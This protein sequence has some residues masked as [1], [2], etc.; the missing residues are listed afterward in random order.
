MNIYFPVALVYIALA[1]AIIAVLWLIVGLF[2]WVWS[3]ATDET[4]KAL[5]IRKNLIAFIKH[6]NRREFGTIAE[7]RSEM[8]KRY[9]EYRQKERRLKYRA[10]WALY[11]LYLATCGAVGQNSYIGL[12]DD[13]VQI[14]E[15]EP[16]PFDECCN[17]MQPKFDAWL[18]SKVEDAKEQKEVLQKAEANS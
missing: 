17:A 12:T 9:E 14:G 15:W 2:S 13:D 4:L 8:D 6:K 18:A 3:W 16:G 7:I 1:I 10:D 5:R 11:H